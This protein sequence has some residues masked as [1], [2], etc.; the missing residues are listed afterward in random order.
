MDTQRQVVEKR[1]PFNNKGE[2]VGAPGAGF[3]VTIV[4]IVLHKRRSFLAKAASIFSPKKALYKPNDLIRYLEPSQ[5]SPGRLQVLAYITS[6]YHKYDPIYKRGKISVDGKYFCYP[7]FN[8]LQTATKSGSIWIL[9]LPSP[10]LDG[11]T[12]IMAFCSSQIK[13][14]NALKGLELFNWAF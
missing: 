3:I 11:Y 8:S 7:D 13:R 2:R 6:G 5:T 14:T 10:V 9:R 4:V 1:I 12:L